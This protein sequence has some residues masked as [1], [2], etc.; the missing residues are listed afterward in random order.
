[1]SW[2]CCRCSFESLGKNG[3]AAYLQPTVGV[4]K[5]TMVRIKCF[6]FGVTFSHA[7]HPFNPP[8]GKLGGG[9]KDCLFSPQP[10]EMIQ[11]DE[12]NFQL[13]WFNHQLEKGGSDPNR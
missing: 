10:G 8:H 3:K 7:C 2:V 4:K 6:L 9:F 12:H 11:F 13:G 5:L 1:M